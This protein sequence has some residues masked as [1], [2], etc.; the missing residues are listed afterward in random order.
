[1]DDDDGDVFKREFKRFKKP[2]QEDMKYV[3]DFT[4]PDKFDEVEIWTMG[5]V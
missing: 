3:I 1:M 5:P 4:Q 2:N